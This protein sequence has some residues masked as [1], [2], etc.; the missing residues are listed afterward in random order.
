MQFSIYI[1]YFVI[2]WRKRSRDCSGIL[3]RV[4]LVESS[5]LI[6][7]RTTKGQHNKI[8]SKDVKIKRGIGIHNKMNVDYIL[9]K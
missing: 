1:I 8:T 9:E 6:E 5:A 2:Y 7:T 3:G 4:V